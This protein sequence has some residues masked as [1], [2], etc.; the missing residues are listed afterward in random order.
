MCE[1]CLYRKNCQFLAKRKNIKGKITNCSAFESEE[2]FVNKAKQKVAM[3]LINE[4]EDNIEDIH[5]R[6]TLTGNIMFHWET[7]K[8]ELK[9]KYIGE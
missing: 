2:N 9:K 3:E 4:F 7:L 6:A 8:F 5:L 1:K